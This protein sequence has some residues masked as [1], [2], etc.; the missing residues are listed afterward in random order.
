MPPRNARGRLAA[1][2]CLRG[3]VSR[4]RAVGM[5]ARMSFDDGLDDDEP[6]YRA[7]LPPDDRLWRHPSEVATRPPRHGLFEQSPWALALLWG[8]VG[9]MLAGGVVIAFGVCGPG[10]G[11]ATSF[12]RG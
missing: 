8:V 1:R 2:A 10:E 5:L 7:P 6:G 4:M 12:G 3:A 11:S 9:A